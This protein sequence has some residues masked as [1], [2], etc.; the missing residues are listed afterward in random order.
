MA[1]TR[2]KMTKAGA[3]AHV[4]PGHVEAWK[5]DGWKAAP[6]PKRKA[7]KDERRSDSE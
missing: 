6:A 1:G 3:V 2:V 4:L 5:A 7:V